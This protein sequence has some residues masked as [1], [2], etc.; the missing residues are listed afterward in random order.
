[1]S[2]VTRVA[3]V[4]PISR[5]QA[6]PGMPRKQMPALTPATDLAS[7]VAALNKINLVLQQ[8]TLPP[9]PNNIGPPAFSYPSPTSNSSHTVDGDGGLIWGPPDWQQGAEIVV[10]KT[11]TYAAQRVFGKTVNRITSE[12]GV[13]DTQYV[14]VK[15]INKITFWDRNESRDKF[16]WDYEGDE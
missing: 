11:I 10:D 8:L 2:M 1:M 14:Y 5:G 16:E 9:A 4:C 15:R 3:P 12:K 6:L 13:D 7:L